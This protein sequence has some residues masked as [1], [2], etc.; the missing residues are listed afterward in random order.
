MKH[1]HKI[2]AF[3]KIIIPQ[4]ER[5][6]TSI[7][8]AM[9]KNYIGMNLLLFENLQCGVVCSSHGKQP[10]KSVCCVSMDHNAF[11][12]KMID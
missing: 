3:H 10:F 6:S 4:N 1:I 11:C 7:S 9:L 2:Q 8:S 12:L 5:S